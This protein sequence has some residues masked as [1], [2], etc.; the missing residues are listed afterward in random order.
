MYNDFDSD[1]Y[2]IFVFEWLK[3]SGGQAK[4]KVATTTI[5][6][7]KHLNS[8]HDFCLFVVFSGHNGADSYLNS[9]QNQ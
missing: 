7:A 8:H 4:V 3:V 1:K 6:Y 5:S 2:Y 9:Q